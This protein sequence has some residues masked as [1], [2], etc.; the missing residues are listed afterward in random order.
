MPALSLVFA[1]S[2][3]LGFR[4]GVP[5]AVLVGEEVVGGAGAVDDFLISAS[6]TGRGEMQ[7]IGFHQRRRNRFYLDHGKGTGMGWGRRC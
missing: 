4:R 7:V 3:D 2:S 5:R 1:V 6:P